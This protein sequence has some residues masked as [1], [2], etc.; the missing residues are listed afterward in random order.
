M[1]ADEKS[2]IGSS[3]LEFFDKIYIINLPSRKDRL[4]EIIKQLEYI[5]IDLPS[6][7]IKIFEAIRPSRKD[8]WPTIG[9]KGCFLSHLGVLKD[10]QKNKYE[11]ILVLEDDVNFVENFNDLIETTIIQ[12]N[13]TSWDILYGGYQKSDALDLAK[14]K[15]GQPSNLQNT[16]RI[17]ANVNVVCSHFI[18]INK[19]TVSLISDY[20]ESILQ[21]PNGHPKGGPMHVDG[22]Y[23]W[24][25]KTH[26]EIK[27]FISSPELCYQRSSRTDI[28]DL[29]WYDSLPM[30]GLVTNLIRKIKNAVI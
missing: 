1:K 5:G 22:A 7:K 17:D 28:H 11:K 10:A 27:T 13:N 19:L 8:D 25:R 18:A 3:V 24:F 2:N 20:F 21:R 16:I 30:F 29:K 23:S 14:L 9:A 12:L 6:N 15:F 26:P 4:T